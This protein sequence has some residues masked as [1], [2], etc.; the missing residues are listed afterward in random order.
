MSS[1]M[2][3]RMDVDIFIRAQEAKTAAK[4]S[5]EEGEDQLSSSL[6]LDRR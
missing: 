2:L 3:E 6:L 4:H 5:R 1:A